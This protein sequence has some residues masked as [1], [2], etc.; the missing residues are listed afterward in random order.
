MEDLLI[1]HMPVVEVVLVVIVNYQVFQFLLQHI[2]YLL[3]VAVL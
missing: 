3:E 1:Q 2:Q